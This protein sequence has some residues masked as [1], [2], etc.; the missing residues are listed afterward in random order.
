M[1]DNLHFE[2]KHLL[3]SLY[4]GLSNYRK[5]KLLELSRPQSCRK[6]NNGIL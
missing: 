1:I 4:S 6:N 2:K 5:T 3:Y